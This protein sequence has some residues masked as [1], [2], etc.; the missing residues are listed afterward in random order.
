M[1]RTALCIIMISHCCHC[2]PTPVQS[3]L[4]GLQKLQQACDMNHDDVIKWKQYP[5]YWPFVREFTGHRWIPRTK[6][7]DAELWCFL[8]SAPWMNGWVNTREAG[9]LR[10]HRAHYDVIFN[11]DKIVIS[12]FILTF[13]VN[14]DMRTIK[15]SH[16]K[17]R[18]QQ[19]L[20]CQA[21]TSIMPEIICWQKY[22][23]S[24]F[25]PFPRWDYP[26]QKTAF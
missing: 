6:P 18:P 10:R 4:N 26:D 16:H 8:W 19:L 14:A 22:A 2:S 7:S 17:R 9:D 25:L 21:D 20:F 11:R 13:P 24:S 3:K 12:F 23:P 15:S 1:L 5:R